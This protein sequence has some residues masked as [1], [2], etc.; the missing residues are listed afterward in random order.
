M[1]YTYHHWHKKQVPVAF[2]KVLPLLLVGHLLDIHAVLLAH[3]VIVVHNIVF[4]LWY[5]LADAAP[6]PLVALHLAW[7]LV[8][9]SLSVLRT[10]ACRTFLA[11]AFSR[12]FGRA[13]VGVLIGA[14]CPSRHG[15]SYAV[16]AITVVLGMLMITLL[17]L[18]LHWILLLLLLM[19]LLM[20][21]LLLL[22]VA[23]TSSLREH[24]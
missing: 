22:R 15:A 5:G 16:L 1:Y 21:L 7:C 20:L 14:I 17:Q 24:E 8:G 6:L 2:Q 11:P 12:C 10:L 13:V 19:L 18:M 4:V 23:L 3:I 9:L